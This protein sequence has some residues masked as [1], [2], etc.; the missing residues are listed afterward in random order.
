MDRESTYDFAQRS[1]NLGAL[2]M[3]Y[4]K[5]V[6]EGLP[7]SVEEIID[8]AKETKSM[9]AVELKKAIAAYK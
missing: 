5:L 1:L 4:L 6:T 7:M 9:N 2:Q 8:C 3:E